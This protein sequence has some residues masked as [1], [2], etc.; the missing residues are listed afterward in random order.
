MASNAAW[1][2]P[3]CMGC[4]SWKAQGLF[5]FGDERIL[6]MEEGIAC[7]LLRLEKTIFIKEK[8]QRGFPLFP[9]CLDTALF[10][11]WVYYMWFNPKPSTK[12]I[13]SIP[14]VCLKK[15]NHLKAFKVFVPKSHL[16]CQVR[17]KPSRIEFIGFVFVCLYEI[18]KLQ[19]SSNIERKDKLKGSDWWV[20]TWPWS[21]KGSQLREHSTMESQ[22]T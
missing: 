19:Q 22:V 15:H 8:I 4:V 6:R 11:S 18:R 16:I 21:G 7:S 5:Q 9:V 10:L 3:L 20:T 1:L 13:F 17:E 12:Y 2:L 14:S